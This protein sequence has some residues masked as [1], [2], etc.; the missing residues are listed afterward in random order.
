MKWKAKLSELG[1]TEETISHGLRAKIKDYNIIE[2]GIVKLQSEMNE[3]KYNDSDMDLAKNDLQEL[4]TDLADYDD[5][6]V[7]AIETFDK[8]KDRYAANAKNLKNVKKTTPK[9][10]TMPTPTPNKSDVPLTPIEEVKDGEKKG[11]SFG[12]VLFAVFAGVITLGAVNILKN[13]E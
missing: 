7:K 11:N 6:L 13:R 12:W 8:N 5:A 1:L 4:Q 9:V 10:E 2:K 3:G